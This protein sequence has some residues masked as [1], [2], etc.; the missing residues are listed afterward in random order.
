MENNEEESELMNEFSRIFRQGMGS[1][2]Q[3]SETRFRMRQERQ[4]QAQKQHGTVQARLAMGLRLE[5][6]DPDFYQHRSSR[7]IADAVTV[8]G[9]MGTTQPEASKALFIA[10]RELRRQGINL[11]ELHRQHPNA[12]G[13][14][15]SALMNQIDDLRNAQQEALAAESQ[16]LQAELHESV[17]KA[18]GISVEEVPAFLEKEMEK[19]VAQ[20]KD[21][22]GSEAETA[23][24]RETEAQKHLDK[25]AAHE[26]LAEGHEAAEAGFRKDAESRG[27]QE[28][29]AQGEVNLD[30]AEAE[31]SPAGRESGAGANDTAPTLTPGDNAAQQSASSGPQSSG[32]YRRVNAGE[33]ALVAQNAPQHALARARQAANFP[34]G[35]TDRVGAT[36][37]TRPARGATIT[38]T[39]RRQNVSEVSR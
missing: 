24:E 33:L 9:E 30:K 39:Q 12:P 20:G 17:A 13:E 11:G 35:T 27:A 15:H 1:G 8:A 7:D 10:E 36:K 2:L 6:S 4:N 16:R 26:D 3:V 14:V 25:A 19:L 38:Q 5:M 18:Q 23:N 29:R 28:D 34:Q 21:T 37:A 22:D 32:S 31:R